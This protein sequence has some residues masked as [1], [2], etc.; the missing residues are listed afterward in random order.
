MFYQQH[1]ISIAPVTTATAN[2]HAYLKHYTRCVAIGTNEAIESM[3][4]HISTDTVVDRQCNLFDMR[5]LR[6]VC[7]ELPNHSTHNHTTRTL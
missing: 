7:H 4:I 3:R 2:R 5:R 1:A 6:Q